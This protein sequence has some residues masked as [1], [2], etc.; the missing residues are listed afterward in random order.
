MKS[1]FVSI[2]GRPNVG[3]STLINNLIGNKVA[4]ISDKPQTTR[5]NIQGI[6]HGNDCQIVFVDTPGIHRPNHK[7]GSYLNKQAYYSFT[8][9]DVIL[10]LVDASTDLG[11]GDR[12]ILERLKTVK[13]PVILVIN[14]IDKIN[15]AL[16][17]AKIIEYKDL[18]TFKEIVPISAL[19]NNNTVEL[20]NVIKANLTD[21]IKYYGDEQITNKSQLFLIAELV[22]EKV[23]NLTLEE[24]PHSV[25]C[26]V[27][28]MEKKNNSY[29]IHVTIIIDRDSLKKIILG[30]QGSKIKQIGIL[31]RKDIE[32]LLG[33]KVYLELFVKT[34][35][36]W[37]D[38]DKYL[39]EF[40]FNLF[41]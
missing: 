1:G 31:A 40:G 20:M 25:T 41:E 10:F 15:N 12:F 13:V 35:K 21:T 27:E 36:K 11:P 33:T 22:R 8:D 19:K 17:I 29:L 26:V 5:N 24:V 16:L 6:Y 2:I 37:R 4:I 3:K 38:K 39:A 14:K 9:A 28:Q 34:I 18:F 32:E 30:K 23:F 7:L